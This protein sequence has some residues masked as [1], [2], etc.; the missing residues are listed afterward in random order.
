M[1]GILIIIAQSIYFMINLIF[2][3]IGH[4]Y[5][6]KKSTL[7]YRIITTITN[8]VAIVFEIIF[9]KNKKIG[10]I[11]CAT[12]V[13]MLGIVNVILDQINKKVYFETLKERIIKI[14][15]QRSTFL[16][17]QDFRNILSDEYDIMYSISDI[18]K[19]LL[20]IK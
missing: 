18:K 14:I 2:P 8:I 7:F 9:Y 20:L 13:I 6:T 5:T 15:D 19:V 4:L 17:I 10:L 3:E 1:E 16:T 11:I 12:T